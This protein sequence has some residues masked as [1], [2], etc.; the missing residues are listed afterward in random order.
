MAASSRPPSLESDYVSPRTKRELEIAGW[1]RN[2]TSLTSSNEILDTLV[3][4]S[5]A[6][7]RRHVVSQ[8]LDRSQEWEPILVLDG[9]HL[10]N[11]QRL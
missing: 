6:L 2:I 10:K 4:S 1:D 9:L 8:A 3:A 7:Q 5:F 11:I